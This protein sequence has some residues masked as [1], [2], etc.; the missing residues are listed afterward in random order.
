MTWWSLVFQAR[1]HTLGWLEQSDSRVESTSQSL[2]NQVELAT[3][4]WSLW[5][6]LAL[7]LQIE[8]VCMLVVF[9]FGY[10][11]VANW[12]LGKEFFIWWRTMQVKFLNF[13][14]FCTYF[15]LDVL[16]SLIPFKW[17]QSL[18]L[19]FTH[20]KMSITNVVIEFWIGCYGCGHLVQVLHLKN[21]CFLAFWRLYTA[22]DTPM[23]PGRVFSSS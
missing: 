22:W 7:D 6:V 12:I 4:S 17:Y 11:L 13:T 19:H 1:G 5:V 8:C 2:K 16:H 15:R 3:H 23:C 20:A 21:A 14:L 9:I 10:V 18:F